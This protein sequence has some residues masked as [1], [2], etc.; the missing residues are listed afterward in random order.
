MQAVFFDL[1]KAFDCVPHCLLIDKLHQLEIPSHL[2]RWV[3]SY[4]HNQVQQVGVLGKLSSP[5]AVISG[6]PQ[7][8]VLGPLL[9]LIY[10]N[11]LSGIQLSGGSVVLFVDD[12]LFHHLITCS[13][14]LCSK[15]H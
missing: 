11:G 1:Q 13:E 10:I 2:I 7:G 12:F 9:F 14:D 4:L 3:S 6:V 5:T 8:S 15:R